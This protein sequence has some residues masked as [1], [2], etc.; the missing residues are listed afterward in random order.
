MRKSILEN[1]THKKSRKLMRL[2]F[3]LNYDILFAHLHLALAY[4]L[5]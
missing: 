3:I 4:L 2:F 1:F 5:I